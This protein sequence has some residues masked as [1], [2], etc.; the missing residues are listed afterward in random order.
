[1]TP[2]RPARDVKRGARRRARDWDAV[3]TSRGGVLPWARDQLNGRRVRAMTDPAGSRVVAVAGTSHSPMVTLDP[4]LI[5]PA[6]A[7]ADVTNPWLYD[8]TGAVRAYDDLVAEAA[9]R[10]D[11]ELGGEVQAARHALALASIERLGRDILALRPDLVIPVG[12]DQKEMYDF[13]NFPA[14]SLYYGAEV[15]IVPPPSRE[16]TLPS[17]REVRLMQGLDGSVHPGDPDAGRRLVEQLTARDFDVAAG[18][19][20]RDH[21]PHQGFGHAVAFVLV[22]LLRSSGI[23]CVPVL[24]NTYFP[25]N[26]PSPRRCVDLGRALAAAV[27]TLPGGRRAVVIASGGLSH[28]VVDTGLDAALLNAM[29]SGDLAALAALPADRMNSGTSEGR[30]WLVAAGAGGAEGLAHQWSQYIPAY[31]SPAGTGTGLAFGLWC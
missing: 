5:W 31:R 3:D 6:R 12:D 28:F 18:N 25:P 11:A 30:N 23:P 10:F 24:L 22:R 21:G 13:D 19:K 29:R 26:Q 9:G 15:P 17:E 1:M 7:L 4:A 14:V 16:P 20:I 8:N 27:R 2:A